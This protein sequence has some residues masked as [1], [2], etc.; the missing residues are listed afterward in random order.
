MEHHHSFFANPRTYIAVAFLIFYALVGRKLWAALAG[1]LDKRAANVRAELDEAAR[2][3]REAEELLREATAQREQ[4]LKDADAVLAQAR[5]EAAR[6]ADAARA[7][8][9]A[10]AK[11]RQRMAMDR[12]AAAEKAA[13]DDVRHAAADIA[14]SAAQRLLAQDLGPEQ[15]AT[16]ID[17]AIQ[18]LPAALAGRRAA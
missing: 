7:E 15:D 2:L 13:V 18:T 6:V 17:R 16:L 14:T 10:A 11:R 12:I 3:R 5:S 8:A 9:E 4:A 1:M